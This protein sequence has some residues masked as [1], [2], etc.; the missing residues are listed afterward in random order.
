MAST[1]LMVTS[2]GRRY[3]KISVSRGYGKSPYSTRFYWPEGYSQRAAER[4]LRKYVAEYEL[5]CS[6]GEILTREERKQQEAQARAELA[7]LKTVRQY[8]NG[9]FMPVKLESVSENTRASYQSNLDLHILPLIG[10][11]LLTDVT[12]AILTKLLLDFRRSHSF[13]ST[14]KVYNILNGLFEMALFDDSIAISPMSKVKRPKQRKEEKAVSEADKA[15]SANELNYVLDCVAG[16]PL[17]WQ[18]YM[19]LAADSAARRGELCGLQ[20]TD[21]DFERGIVT[22][23]HNLQYSR[24]KGVYNVA[25]K[26]GK[27]REVDIGEDTIALLKKHRQDQAVRRVSKWVFSADGE[28]RPIFPT[29]P[30]RYFES[31]G[32][33]YGIPGFHPHLLRHTS[34]S[35]SLTNG[36]DI[37]S[38][39]DRLGHADASTT[40][41]MYAH[42][43]ADSIRRAGQA[44]RDALKRQKEAVRNAGSEGQCG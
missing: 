9:V 33:R 10:D 21:I 18:A 13:A 15:L 7:K 35:L 37:K 5:K 4:E 42:A 14:I 43:D 20:W 23:R 28:D 22:F 26:S 34:A 41:R 12:P 1:K 6:R 3:W 16:E 24:A 17:Q 8:A 36:G 29:S 32:R 31:F 30:T 44:A 25:P 11:M 39:A 2:D 19:Y 38:I 27:A 40:L